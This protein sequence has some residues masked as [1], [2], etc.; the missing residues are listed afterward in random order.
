MRHVLKIKICIVTMASS[1]SSASRNIDFWSMRVEYCTPPPRHVYAHSSWCWV[2]LSTWLIGDQDVIIRQV[3]TSKHFGTRLVAINFTSSAIHCLWKR[4]YLFPR[5][6][7]EFFYVHYTIN[8]YIR[9]RV[10]PS[11]S[12][13]PP[14]LLCATDR[15]NS[16]ERERIL[17]CCALVWGPLDQGVI[18]ISTGFP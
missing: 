4:S 16:S 10:R 13:S 2:M 18:A 12:L 8:I 14:P 9:K 17:K 5:T 7:L 11:I 3:P 1:R 15:R 6:Y